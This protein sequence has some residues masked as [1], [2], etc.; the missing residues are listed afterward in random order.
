MVNRQSLVIYLLA[1]AL[2]G[3]FY[4]AL[5]A[6]PVPSTMHFGRSFAGPDN[7]T[8]L[9]HSYLFRLSLK[10]TLY[11]WLGVSLMLWLFS[12]P[13]LFLLTRN[14]WTCGV[15]IVVLVALLFI[16]I[17]GGWR[18]L[19]QSLHALYPTSRALMAIGFVQTL[20]LLP[21]VMLALL[22]QKRVRSGERLLTI[23]AITLLALLVDPALPLYLT[24]GEPFN[25]THTWAGWGWQLGYV[26]RQYGQSAAA[27]ISMVPLFAFGVGTLWWLA[28][29]EERNKGGTKLLLLLLL[30]SIPF[31]RLL[32]LWVVDG[33]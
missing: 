13:M 27:L 16:P 30:S 12:R 26:M 28:L 33:V 9:A 5:S 17:Y 21:V 19:L 22:L 8:A 18:P 32:F 25:S 15:M 23:A 6:E 7:F 31:L 3:T 1:V 2:L 24:G 11:L 20:R 14:R 4:L 10:N 29:R